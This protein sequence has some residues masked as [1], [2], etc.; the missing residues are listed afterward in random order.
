MSLIK[1][2]FTC[3]IAFFISAVT[4]AQ[5]EVTGSIITLLN[6]EVNNLPGSFTNVYKEPTASEHNQWEGMILDI[7]DEKYGNAATKASALAYELFKVTDDNN[8]YY[9]LKRAVGSNNYWGIYV[10][11]SM[12]CRSNLVIQSPH[13]LADRN[14]GKEGAFVFKETGA[15]AFFLSGTHRCNNTTFSVCS[16]TTKVCS[17][18]SSEKY[19]I[20]DVAHN[21]SSLYQTTTK[22]LGDAKNP[23]FVQ[24]HGFTKGSN[25][26]YVIM[27][28][29][30]RVLE[31]TDKLSILKDQLALEDNSLTFK[32]SHIDLDWNKLLAFTNTQGR[33]INKSLDP[34][35]TNAAK[36]TGRF[37]HIE[38]EY[39]KLRAGQTQWA[40][41][42]NALNNTFS[43]GEITA[44]D[45]QP[46]KVELKVFPNP[47]HNSLSFEVLN[48]YKSYKLRM[49]NSAGE[50]VMSSKLFSTLKVSTETWKNGIY[51]YQI[52]EDE[53]FIRSGKIIKQ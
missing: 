46:H 52:F 30:A 9:L 5:T 47:T 44:I 1:Y 36:A 21:T 33:Y 27:S 43:C 48:P 2:I 14:T 4:H 10:F 25:D 32:L 18:S 3:V 45:N 8:V 31:G 7:L 28:N 24:L 40:K 29:G 50:L 13:P 38:Q 34:C 20:S 19:K 39:N 26:P 51:I 53:K 16:G 41:V 17:G 37:I 15:Y 35:G 12:A 6:T 49:F 42:A 23:Y 11:N 22:V